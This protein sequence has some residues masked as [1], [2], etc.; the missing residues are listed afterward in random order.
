MLFIP[1]GN[2][3]IPV[4]DD[5]SQT[6][7][8]MGFSFPFYKK[9]YSEITIS[10]NGYVVF[11]SFNSSLNSSCCF[12]I[13][14]PQMSN[15]I[16]A[17]NYDL[18][19]A[20]NGNVFY[21]SVDTFSADLYTIQNE[22]NQLLRTNFRASN[23]FVVTYANIAS[24]S[25]RNDVANFQIILTTDSV[26]SY[27]TLNYGYC[28]QK[29]MAFQIITEIDCLDKSLNMVVNSI[30]NPC[31]SSNVNVIGKWIFNVTDECKLKH[32]L[33]FLKRVSLIKTFFFAFGIKVFRRTHQIL[34]ILSVHILQVLQPNLLVILT[35]LVSIWK[36]YLKIVNQ[37]IFSKLIRKL[38][39][40]YLH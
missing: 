22:I 13:N 28:L 11:S 40:S 26:Q 24:Y 9:Y 33:K 15:L 12:G 1:A 4:G 37:N 25:D 32:N 2:L 29:P 36:I 38:I 7:D 34:V 27:L 17:Y 21:R 3:A 35:W 20:S 30:V 39:F 6:V 10:T 16:S 23:A 31:T 14:R 18:I 5:N 8:F 19:S